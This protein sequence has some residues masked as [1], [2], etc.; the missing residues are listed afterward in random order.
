M[1]GLAVVLPLLFIPFSLSHPTTLSHRKLS[2]NPPSTSKIHVPLTKRAPVTSS[3]ANITLYTRQALRTLGKVSKGI[4][5]FEHN[6]GSTF[7]RVPIK[8]TT[9]AFISL[10]D[11]V[12][13]GVLGAISG[14]L[15]NLLGKRANGT[16]V[17]VDDS[18]S[19]WHGSIQVGTP[20]VAFTVDFDSGSA[21]LFLPGPDC[22][23]TCDGHI[24]YNPANSSTSQAL[25]QT[26][27]LGFGDGSQVTGKQFNDS[28]TIANVTSPTQTLGVASVYSGFEAASFPPD[29]LMGL[30][31]PA[32][33]G[34]QGHPVFQNLVES[35]V[36]DEPVFAF[37]FSDVS[38][39]SQLTIGGTNT[40]LFNSTAT[41]TVKVTV[42]AYWQVDIEAIS[43]GDTPAATNVS[44]I[45]D[46]GTTLILGDPDTVN[47]TYALIPGAADASSIIDPCNTTSLPSL[48]FGGRA[49]TVSSAT[50]NLGLL[51][52][53]DPDTCVGGLV[54]ADTGVGWIVGDV[55]LR[56][57]YTIFD[58]EKQ[59][60]TFADLLS[61]TE[62]DITSL[63]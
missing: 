46:T 20:P 17:L 3:V 34:M 37:K 18:D 6:T 9:S 63:A 61:A 45:I 14:A 56:N 52:A 55:F 51:S 12:V 8:P 47:K 43:V 41:G 54:A 27:S 10:V 42:P 39:E 62:P 25:G 32:I 29:G 23:S 21:D 15:K 7:A 26:F 13:T 53:A 48:T 31:F 11:P 49:F 33:S 5:A 38:G 28:L 50:F 44:S 35:G 60:V 40:S 36:L 1:L 4:E 2:L 57:V 58:F 24:I 16:D 30:G 22:G 19:L 59:T